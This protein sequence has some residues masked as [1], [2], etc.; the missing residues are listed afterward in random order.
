[1]KKGLHWTDFI[2]LN[3]QQLKEK[4]DRFEVK[5]EVVEDM[6][7]MAYEYREKQLEAEFNMASTLAEM[8]RVKMQLNLIRQKIRFEAQLSSGKIIGYLNHVVL[9]S[10]QQSNLL[11]VVR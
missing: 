1:M 5:P 11:N 3:Q 6:R 4:I 10:A 8:Q 7:R 2:E 9:G